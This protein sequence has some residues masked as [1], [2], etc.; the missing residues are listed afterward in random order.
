MVA[1]A[2]GRAGMKQYYTRSDLIEAACEDA[3]GAVGPIW[4]L[5]WGMG[6]LWRAI[7]ETEV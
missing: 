4:S 2:G 6:A 3:V 1:A 5:V 7:R